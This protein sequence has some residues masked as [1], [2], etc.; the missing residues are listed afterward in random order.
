VDVELQRIAHRYMGKERADDTLQATALV[1]EV[2]LRPAGWPAFSSDGL[3][4][5]C[6]YLDDAGFLTCLNELFEQHA[7][8]K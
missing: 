2:Y 8:G 5:E 1:N 3:Y 7:N 6:E 4:S